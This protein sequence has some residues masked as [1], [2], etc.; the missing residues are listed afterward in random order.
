MPT[1]IDTVSEIYD[2]CC[3]LEHITAAL[4][5]ILIISTWETRNSYAAFTRDLTYLLQWTPEA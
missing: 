3:K 1:H 5:D 4:G 2:L